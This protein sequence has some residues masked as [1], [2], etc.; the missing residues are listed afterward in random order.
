M[1]R[2]EAAIISAYT[3]ILVGSFADMQAY[4]ETL[5]DRPV[6]THEL[7]DK[8]LHEKIKKKA[9]PDLIRICETVTGEPLI[10]Y[11]SETT[12]EPQ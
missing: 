8:E 7:G 2:E 1:T 12:K 11:R 6:F 4:V 5:F 3:G 10:G 9:K